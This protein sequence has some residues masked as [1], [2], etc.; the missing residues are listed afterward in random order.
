[1][2]KTFQSVWAAL[3]VALL[4]GA[5]T[6]CGGGGGEEGALNPPVVEPPPA[7]PAIPTVPA[8][9]LQADKVELCQ[10]GRDG[11][12]SGCVNTGVS[13]F[14]EL[15]AMAVSGSHFYLADATSGA[16]G[17]IHCSIGANGLLSGCINTEVAGLTSPLALTAEGSTLYIGDTTSL[18]RKCDIAEDGAL[19]CV[20]SAYPEALGSRVE[21]IH[22]VGTTAYIGVSDDIVSCQVVDDGF[23]SDCN[24]TGIS[25]GHPTFSTASA[26]AINGSH[27]Y[28]AE[29]LGD[30]T[31]CIIEDGSLR[32]CEVARRTVGSP[33]QIAIRDNIVYITDTN[34]TISLTRCTVASDGML[35]D[36]TTHPGASFHSMMFN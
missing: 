12:L 19:D 9:L 32:S 8:Y 3:S 34:S 30:I 20:D 4:C 29:S 7:P 23:L 35:T 10:V 25:V 33:S 15:R 26:I 5:M 14:A 27:M 22:I 28:I 21:A 36:C 11:S 24:Y 18:I 1:M 2:N 6:A 17:V 13:G 31:R 16:G